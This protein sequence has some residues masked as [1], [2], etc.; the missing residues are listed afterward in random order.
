MYH[1]FTGDLHNPCKY[2]ASF[3]MVEESLKAVEEIKCKWWHIADAKMMKIIGG[4]KNE[5]K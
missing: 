1:L 2:K 5:E 3:D 4:E